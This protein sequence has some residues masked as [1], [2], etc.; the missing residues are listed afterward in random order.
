[1]KIKVFRSWV[2]VIAL[3]MLCVCCL[4]SVSMPKENLSANQNG[5]SFNFDKDQILNSLKNDLISSMNQDLIKR[6][7]DYRLSGTVNVI[8][9]LSN[10]SLVSEFNKKK[11][12]SSLADFLASKESVSIAKR[13]TERQDKLANEMIKQGL[14]SS[15]KYHY[16]TIMDGFY[17]TTTYANIAKICSFSGV[18]RVILS[19][20]YLPDAA[21][22]N[23][24]NVDDTGIFKSDGVDYTGKGTIVAI[25]DTGCDYT[26]S[27]FTTRQVENPLYSRD[28][29]AAMLPDTTAYHSDNSLEVRQVYYGNITKDK[30]AYGYD[31]ADNDPDIMPFSS[32]HGTHVAG[33]IG[34]S[35]N[36]IT[37]VAIDTQ[38]AIMKVFSDFRDGADDGDIMAAL[39]DCVK[40]NVDAI[41]MSLGTSAGF[42]IERAEDNL[43]KNDIYNSIQEA[44]ISLVCAASNDYS[45]GFGSEFGNTNKVENPDSGTVGAPSTFDAALSVA[46]ING[47]KDKYMLAN[48]EREIFFL[49]AY[50]QSAKEYNFFEML[51]VRSGV[52]DVYEY[53]TVPGYGSAVNYSTIDVTGKIALVKRGDISFE[54]KVLFAASAGAAAVVIYNNVYG[55]IVMTV[56]NYITI[57]VV[58][59]GK[60]DGEYLAS[61]EK[62]VLAFNGDNQAGPFMSDFSSWG[63]TPDLKLKP[64]ITAHGGNIYSAIPGGGYDKL[65][66]TSMASPNMCGLIVLIR[67]FVKDNFP[68]LSTTEVRDLVNELCMSTATIALDR[69]GNP[70]S[71]RKQ[72]AGIGDILK[73]TT[74]KAYLYVEDEQGHNTGKTKLELGDDPARKGV[75][76]MTFK[77]A[78]ISDVAVSYDLGNYTMTES[79]SADKKYVAERA[80]ILNNASEYSVKGATLTGNTVTVEAGQTATITVKLTLSADDKAYLN[81]SF[82]NGMFVEGFI[83]LT[84][85]A[86]DGVNLNVPFLAFYGDWSDAPIFDKDYYLVE[87]EAHNNAIDDDDKIKADY[88]ATTPFG[89]YFYDYIVPMGTYLYEIDPDYTAIPATAEHAAL[90]YYPTSM[91]G[92]YAVLT[93]LLR[94]AREM[95]IQIVDTATGKVVWE[96]TQYNAY[97]AH[98]NGGAQIP[99]VSQFELDMVD[100]DEGTIFG[101]NNT[102]YEVTMTAKL[103]WDKG[104]RNSND[105]YTFSFYVD[106]EAPTITDSRFYTKYNSVTKKTE[107]YVDLTVY[108]NHYAMAVRP[109]VFMVEDIDGTPTLSAASLKRTPI[110]VYQEKRGSTSVVTVEITDFFDPVKHSVMPDGLGFIVDD[111]ALNTGLCYVPFPEMDSAD[112]AFD[113][114]ESANYDAASKSLVLDVGQTLDVTQLISASGRAVDNTFMFM[115]TWSSDDDSVSVQ[116]GVIKGEKT[117]TARIRFSNKACDDYVDV[118]VTNNLS[119]SPNAGQNVLLDEIGFYSYYTVKAFGGDFDFSTIGETGQ[120][121]F[122]DEYA[123]IEFFPSEKV[124]LNYY[125]RPWSLDESRYTLTWLSS[126]PN[127]ATVD[128]EGVVTAIAEGSC[129]IYLRIIVDGRMSTLQGR[130]DVTVNSEFI[131]ENRELVA[132]KGNGGHVEI[133]SDLGIMYIASFA[134]SN[135]TLDNSLELPEDDRLDIDKKKTAIGNDTVVS[136]IIPEGVESINQYAFYNC[137]KLEYV[138]LPSGLKDIAQFAFAECKSLRNIN[139][140]DVHTVGDF[141]F[142]NCVNLDCNNFDGVSLDNASAIGEG[143]FL[144]CE[145]IKSVKLTNLRRSGM[146]A[147][148]ACTGLTTVELGQYA[149]IAEL[150]FYGCKSISN[151]LVIYS[152]VVPDG[153]FAG[154]SALTSVEFVNDLTY[155]GADAFTACTKLSEVKFDGGCEEFGDYAF[156]DCSALRK[157][158]L[159]DCKMVWGSAVFQNTGLNTLVFQKNSKIVSSGAGVFYNV[160]NLQIDV[161]STEFVYKN[162]VVFDGE[163]KEILFVLPSAKL[164]DYVLPETVEKIADGA[165]SGNKLITSLDASSSNLKEIGKTAFAYCSA[166]KKV[167]LPANGVVLGESA[168]DNC[169]KLTEINLEVVSKIGV[170]AFYKTA[171]TVANV[172]YDGAEI[173]EG[174]ALEVDEGTMFV[175][176][177]V[178]ATE[179]KEVR[180]GANV[181]V[182]AAAFAMTGVTSVTLEGD[183]VQIGDYAFVRC[184]SLKTLDLSKATGKLGDYAFAYCAQLTEVDISQITEIGE[185]TFQ[186]C[187]ALKK[188][189]N[190]NSVKK[191]GYGAFYP[192]STNMGTV[193]VP[194]A[195]FDFS[196]VEVVEDFAFLF[197]PI[198]HLDLSKATHVG[199]YAFAQCSKL[200][201]VRFGEDLREISEAA[202]YGC[203]A[204][205]INSNDLQYVETV[206]FASFAGVKLP[207]A[208]NLTNV[209]TIDDQ[210]FSAHYKDLM[211]GRNN[212]AVANLTR[213]VAPELTYV[214]SSAFSYQRNLKYLEQATKLQT[215]CSGAFFETVIEELELTSNFREAEVCPMEGASKFKGFYVTVNGQK[216][217]D[218]DAGHFMLDGGALYVKLPNGYWQL[219]SYPEGKTDKEYVVKE[220]TARIDMFAFYANQS[221]ETVTLPMTLLSIGDFAFFD[222]TRLQTVIFRSYYAPVLEGSVFYYGE[223]F[224][225]EGS[226]DREFDNENFRELYGRDFYW[227]VEGII[228]AFDPT[229]NMFAY[230]TFVDVIC[231]NAASNLTYVIP[232][233]SEGYDSPMYKAY[234]KD[235]TVTSGKTRGKYTIAFIEAMSKL[236][237]NVDRFATAAIEQAVTAYN[238]LASNPNDVADFDRELV[239]G[240]IE[241][242]KKAL[243]A[244]NVDTVSHIISKLYDMDKTAYSY[245]ALR[246]AFSAFDALTAEEKALVANSAVLNEKL[247]ELKTAMGVEEI[248][249]DK[250]FADYYPEE[251]EGPGDDNPGDDEPKKDW[252][253]VIVLSSVGGALVIAAA[254]VV[255]VLLLKKKKSANA[256]EQAEQTE[257]VE[258]A[259]QQSAEQPD[260]Q[261]GEKRDSEEK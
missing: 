253:L 240:L 241:I 92:I 189:S 12:G 79:L 230:S 255:T 35:D 203:I 11:N 124:R 143:A 159:P 198:A 38:F 98:S 23:V 95:N 188:V 5:N 201:S 30:I 142:M 208:L 138:L 7:D 111:Y 54:E 197:T 222:C 186:A 257:Q 147:F 109:V 53:V 127:V 181:K 183:N 157:L 190:S 175:G 120:T 119:N 4:P 233:D 227:N 89:T 156:S 86:S 37:G 102:H 151:K 78:N 63:P 42:T 104:E 93:G 51:G 200:K 180:L 121:R 52:T 108:D 212:Y 44:G 62:G 254:V 61:Q 166:L 40:L 191:I 106:Y 261:Q 206:G 20:T 244:Y 158:T 176:A 125:I 66:G 34:G 214:G 260:E 49:E 194:I 112:L 152:D 75:Y 107:Y 88:Y 18:D 141:A 247:A 48:G 165:F 32:E 249:F 259:E 210:A 256:S 84:D 47:V 21:V 41:N 184:S 64:E 19:N 55:D 67:Q 137:S 36:T 105:T 237:E 2:I 50:N 114:S 171:I 161:D 10:G 113:P 27:A 228:Y 144:G 195:E 85:K 179:L 22:T 182:G 60:D 3:A 207:P 134:F 167:E 110:P 174:D 164:G 215:L 225:I 87:T 26:H 145:R 72:G 73:A 122:F 239:D 16:S 168:F 83:T 135:Y 97:K 226:N 76:E 224:I 43:Y 15:V 24:V 148:M 209:V 90:S 1:M 132:Y 139:F 57:P 46:S 204:L 173:E 136:V 216:K 8:I 187:I 178:G 217:F 248:D 223:N 13:A 116:D 185:G 45:S 101:D 235:A 39:E 250:A 221:L 33:I 14:I 77:L 229:Y 246:D 9:T 162:G 220:N 129:A 146:G 170:F 242:Y 126:N 140:N 133:P 99:Y 29:I 155:L 82:K 115:F 238:L 17:A 58:S 69:Y 169:E 192:A 118:I 103:D 100:Y 59:I 160:S 81:T 236:P 70:Y 74:T 96:Q 231:S 150:M 56:G 28:D 153:A 205:S 196:S 71:P 130:C 258:Q 252:T 94:G 31:Y 245:N 6:I 193:A 25:L 213:V 123:H 163:E 65:S 117:G 219:S 68:K 211:T 243:V 91:S 149:R 202:F 234:F 80:Y 218:Y 199:E 177:F 154:C 128:D 251:S 131:V 232:D 172:T